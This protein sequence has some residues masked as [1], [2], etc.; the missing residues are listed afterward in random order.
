MRQRPQ[1]ASGFKTRGTTRPQ[2][3]IAANVK[4]SPINSDAQKKAAKEMEKHR[5]K[6]GIVDKKKRKKKKKNPLENNPL[7][8]VTRKK[9]KKVVYKKGPVKKPT[10]P[11]VGLTDKTGQFRMFRPPKRSLE[12]L[13]LAKKDA[14]AVL[15]SKAAFKKAGFEYRSKQEIAEQ[16]LETVIK[17]VQKSR[18]EDQLK[19]GIQIARDAK[20]M[21]KNTVMRKAQ[22]LLQS[23]LLEDLLKA[24]IEECEQTRSEAELKKT[25]KMTVNE[26]IDKQSKAFLRALQLEE[27]LKI[28]KEMLDEAI[29]QLIEQT[30]ATMT[31][32]AVPALDLAISNVQAVGVPKTNDAVVNAIQV[33]DR[34]KKAHEDQLAAEEK[35]VEITK[36]SRETHKIGILPAAIQTC[37]DAKVDDGPGTALE[38]AKALLAA[39]EKE[40][41]AAMELQSML[42]NAIQKTRLIID[43]EILRP[44]GKAR[45]QEARDIIAEA[46]G[47]MG[48]RFEPNNSTLIEANDILKEC[49]AL[50]KNVLDAELFL[51]EFLDNPSDLDQAIDISLLKTK[52]EEALEAHVPDDGS[53]QPLKQAQ[54]LLNDLLNVY[55]L[56]SRLQK[57]ADEAM[58]IV[59][60]VS[61]RSSSSLF[62][63]SD[64]IVLMGKQFMS[65]ITTV[66]QQ[67]TAA[68]K[69]IAEWKLIATIMETRKT[70]ILEKLINPLVQRV[71]ALCS[72][73][74]NITN[75]EN[76]NEGLISIQH[77][78]CDVDIYLQL[79]NEFVEIHRLGNISLEQKLSNFDSEIV[80]GVARSKLHIELI[81]ID[82]SKLT[83]ILEQAQVQLIRPY[84]EKSFYVNATENLLKS[85]DQTKKLFHF[86]KKRLLEATTNASESR[87]IDELKETLENTLQQ[88]FP[89]EDESVLRAQALIT[90]LLGAEKAS[91]LAAKNLRACTTTVRQTRSTVQLQNAINIALNTLNEEHVDVLEAK[92]L[93]QELKADEEALL[94]A[95]QRLKDATVS[96]QHSYEVGFLKSEIQ[97]ALTSNITEETEEMIAARS[98]CK[99]IVQELSEK[100]V[101]ATDEASTYSDI[102]VLKKEIEYCSYVLADESPVETAILK[103]AT[104]KLESITAVAHLNAVKIQAQVRIMH[105][106]RRVQILKEERDND[107]NDIFGALGEAMSVH[108]EKGFKHVENSEKKGEE[109]LDETA[110][111]FLN[112]SIHFKHIYDNPTNTVNAEKIAI[113]TQKYTRRWLAR[114]DWLWFVNMSLFF[115]RLYPS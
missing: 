12:E 97:I 102:A 25:I 77:I 8:K 79:Y 88:N 83:R 58:G 68:L 89:A 81:T 60:S 3:N 101:K 50:L 53:S 66:T 24:K 40:K 9:F 104:A 46:L 15:Y 41:S 105:A 7:G 48:D 35:L 52:I 37:I 21:E 98:L 71:Q 13:N 70:T 72:S 42:L 6:F 2:I 61:T 80:D 39:L 67:S 115:R 22:R 17:A 94:A 110:N 29:Q 32:D 76:K 90:E 73:V 47:K 57:I 92:S 10:K 30:N 69:D 11:G 44:H 54:T 82:A 31:Y 114:R 63:R 107:I 38:S 65:N 5:K 1:V 4:L 36:E 20:I 113:F 19:I 34:L 112:S 100:L 56:I 84:C 75:S 93:L 14:M 106:K 111:F 43:K 99:R 62:D 45:M 49:D 55:D 96:V 27:V 85:I 108:V 109:N 51:S 87:N 74:E 18:N 23:L 103:S 95:L 64:G 86:L 26:G 78:H 28:E 91:E 33:R 59:N 16:A